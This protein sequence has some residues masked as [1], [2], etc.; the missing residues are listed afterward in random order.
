MLKEKQKS[1][2]QLKTD[3][4]LNIKQRVSVTEKLFYVV[5]V[6]NIEQFCVFSRE[7]GILHFRFYIDYHFI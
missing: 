2:L 5:Y 1:K 4:Q 6:Y 7:F 3:Q